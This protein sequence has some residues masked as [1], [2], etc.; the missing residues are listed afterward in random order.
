MRWA[1]FTLS[2][3]GFAAAGAVL[4][5]LVQGQ[6]TSVLQQNLKVEKNFTPYEERR[7]CACLPAYLWA[8]VHVS[9]QEAITALCPAP[10]P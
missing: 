7:Q 4:F 10:V 6:L 9:W 2:A 5:Q 8:A 1:L 3:V